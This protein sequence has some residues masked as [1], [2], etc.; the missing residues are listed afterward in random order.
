LAN[1]DI[2]I[3]V[4]KRYFESI[5]SGEKT[6]ELRRRALR[7]ESGATVWLYC[8]SPVAS[9]SAVCHLDYTE[10]LPIEDLWHKHGQ[11]LALTKNEFEKYLSDRDL[12]T[13]LV[14]SKVQI[15]DE[16]V[17]LEM[18]RKLRINFQPPQ[19]FM[20]LHKSCSLKK[21]LSLSF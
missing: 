3:S 1:R 17:N 15:L 19:F 2:L 11:K 12:G 18:A 10:T 9:I 4:E 6:V 16:P 8:K 20:Y 14:L 7:V 5:I 13:A 21:K